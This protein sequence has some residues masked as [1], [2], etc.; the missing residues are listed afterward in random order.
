[1]AGFGQSQHSDLVPF[2]LSA[3]VMQTGA[4]SHLYT[5]R[6]EH[7]FSDLGPALKVTAFLPQRI[8]VRGLLLAW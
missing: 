4:E 7:G 2:L 6:T 5:Q 3:G 1:M 8:G